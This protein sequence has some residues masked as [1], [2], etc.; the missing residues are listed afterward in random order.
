MPNT[1]YLPPGTYRIRRTLHW[2]K[3]YG[4]RIVGHGRDTRI[5]WDGDGTSPPVM[6]HSDGATA[7]VLFEGLVWD[8]AGKAEIGVNHCSSTHYESHVTHRNEAFFNLKAG[9]VTSASDYFPYRMPLPR[10]SSITACSS[11]LPAA[12]WPSAVTTPWTIR[13]STAGFYY[14][15]RAIGNYVGNVYVRRCHFEGSLDADIYTHVGDCAALRCT[16]VGSKRFLHAGGQMF[17]MQDC[18]VDG[19]TSNKGAVKRHSPDPL[20]LFDCTHQPAW[21]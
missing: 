12:A 8:G 7:G 10:C 16:S 3:L 6:F 9:I 21:P 13:S 18:H 17:V 2:Q 1:V 4:K 14:C 11:T 19:W 15:G 5:V 20:T